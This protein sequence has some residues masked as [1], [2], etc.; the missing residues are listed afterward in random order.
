MRPSASCA[1]AEP[2]KKSAKDFAAAAN[3]KNV[4]ARPRRTR[5][6]ISL[7][8]DTAFAGMRRRNCL[9]RHHS[10]VS[11][12]IPGATALVDARKFVLRR[13]RTLHSRR[14]ARP[15]ICAFPRAT[16]IE[17]SGS[18]GQAWVVERRGAEEKRLGPWRAFGSN[19]VAAQDN[20]R[21]PPHRKE[22]P[23][24]ILPDKK[25][26]HRYRRFAFTAR[27][28]R[29]RATGARLSGSFVDPDWSAPEEPFCIQSSL[30]KSRA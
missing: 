14:P 2:E 11:E 30:F 16:D 19:H 10:K 5:G 3:F 29:S 23:G 13:T 1:S 22:A 6:P 27:V 20:G 24:R 25:S 28:R 17:K 15:P 12:S 21:P 7:A 9:K 18:A 8:L 4:P 26:G